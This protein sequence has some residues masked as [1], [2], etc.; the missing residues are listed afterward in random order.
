[1]HYISVECMSFDR[2]INREEV[3]F[4]QVVSSML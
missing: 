4:I 2:H 3:C 1:M